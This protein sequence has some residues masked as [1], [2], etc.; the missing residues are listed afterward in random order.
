MRSKRDF[1]KGFFLALTIVFFLAEAV[2]A[3]VGAKYPTL[4]L[5]RIDVVSSEEFSTVSTEAINIDDELDKLRVEVHPLVQ[6]EDDDFQ[7]ALIVKEWVMNQASEVG[8]DIKA[9]TPYAIL[10]EMRQGEPASCGKMSLVYWGALKSID[11]EARLVQL[12]RSMYNKGDTHVVVEALINDKW[13]VIDAYFNIYFVID[14][15]LASATELHQLLLENAYPKNLE[16]VE[17]G[18]VSYPAKVDA[19]PLDP[20]TLYNHVFVFRH[21]F[22]G[23]WQRLPLLHHY[24]GNAYAMVEENDSQ[25]ESTFKMHNCLVLAYDFYFPIAF[26]VSFV[27]L[28]AALFIPPKG[29][30]G[31]VYPQNRKEASSG[32]GSKKHG[33]V[34]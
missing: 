17:G 34:V 16:V 9:L 21:N 33:E 7:K 28:M 27:A 4:D 30:K 13:V 1:V 10:M 11:M 6:N 32:G 25:A 5:A 19:S 8:L 24:F 15:K 22:T 29:K 23:I 3:W 14:G 20:L 26:G 12:V 31:Q 2:T 18:E